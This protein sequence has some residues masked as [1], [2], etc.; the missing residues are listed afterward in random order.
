MYVSLVFQAVF[1]GYSVGA[2]PIIGYQYG[3]QNHKEL[4]GV[5]QKSLVLVSIFA[6]AMF[7]SSYMMKKPLSVVFVGYD[8]GLLELTVRAFSIFSF[9][10]LFSGYAIFG[11]SFFTALNNGVVSAAISFLRTFVFQAAAVLVFPLFWKLDGIWLSVVA[12]EVMAV[13]VT[14]IFFRVKQKEYRY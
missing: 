3:A 14:V 12:A 9:S 11:S 6:A 8:Q 10:F 5:Y 1:I 13:V 2:A 4:K 7:V